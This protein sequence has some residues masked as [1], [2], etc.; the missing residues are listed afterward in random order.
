MQRTGKIVLFILA[1]RDYALLLPAQMPVSTNFGIEVNIHFIFVKYGVFR[2][3]FAS[4]S[5]IATI[6]LLCVGHG[7]AVSALLS[8]IP[9]R[10][11][12]TIAG[13]LKHVADNR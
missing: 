7:Y 12:V 4:A 9:V 11:Q 2:T 1:Q 10:Q 5:W 13:W 8:A 6:F 3:A